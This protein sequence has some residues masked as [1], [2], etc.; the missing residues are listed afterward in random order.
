LVRPNS[1][2]PVG[3]NEQR[4]DYEYARGVTFQVF[5]PQDG[6]KQTV[7]LPTVQGKDAAFLSLE[8]LGS[9]LMVEGSG[10]QED[11]TIL[12]NRIHHVQRVDGSAFSGETSGTRVVVPPG[13]PKIRIHLEPG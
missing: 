6:T 13:A 5:E 3:A 2:L 12:L 8:R 7:T 11:C 4:P 10:I 9:E 1:I